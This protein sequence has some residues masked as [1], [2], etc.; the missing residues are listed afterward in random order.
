MTVEQE[1]KDEGGGGG[2]VVQFQDK[3]FAQQGNLGEL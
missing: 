3:S 2:T 1:R